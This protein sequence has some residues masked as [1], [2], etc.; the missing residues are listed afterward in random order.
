[1]SGYILVVDDQFGVRLLIHKVL[2]ES[3]YNVKAVASGLECLNHAI[4]LNRPSLI[5]LDQRMPAM[6]GIQVLSRLS[7]D[8]QAKDIP[9]IMISAETDLEDLARC[10]GVQNFLSKPLD[11]N[12]LLKTVQETLAGAS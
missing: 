10:F 2:E 11:L 9:V 12:V 1:M 4:S 5:L 8:D 7:Q 3:G 6:T